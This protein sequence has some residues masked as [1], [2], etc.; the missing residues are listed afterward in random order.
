MQLWDPM[1]SFPWGDFFEAPNPFTQKSKYKLHTWGLLKPPRSLFELHCAWLGM[2][3][4]ARS[5]TWHRKPNLNQDP[6][7]NFTL[8]VNT[9]IHCI[10]GASRNLQD[11]LWN[12]TLH[13]KARMHC[14]LALLERTQMYTRVS[15]NKCEINTSVFKELSKALIYTPSRINAYLLLLDIWQSPHLYVHACDGFLRSSKA[16]AYMPKQVFWGSWSSR[17]PSPIRKNTLKWIPQ[18]LETFRSPYMSLNNFRSRSKHPRGVQEHSSWK[19]EYFSNTHRPYCSNV[20][21]YSVRRQ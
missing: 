6:L 16:L 17:K 4:H 7:W 13:I 2:Q 15:W 14:I 19:I 8:Q 1:A 10:W 5:S 18:L 12:F 11:S 21:K 20:I 9:N 3:D